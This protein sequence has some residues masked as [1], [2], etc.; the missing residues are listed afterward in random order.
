[1]SDVV[2][3]DVSGDGGVVALDDA[4]DA[5]S[6]GRPLDLCSVT[7]KF[8]VHEEVREMEF[9]VDDGNGKHAGLDWAVKDM[10]PGIRRKFRMSAAYA[11]EEVDSHTIVEVEL[12]AVSILRDSQAMSNA[13]KI[14]FAEEMRADGNRS[15]SSGTFARAARRYSSAVNAIAI[16]QNYTADEKSAVQKVGLLCFLNRAQCC[17]KLEQWAAARRD[18]EMALK[19]DSGSVKAHYRRG[20]AC[21]NLGQWEDAKTSLERVLAEEAANVGARRELQRVKLALKEATQRERKAYARAFEKPLYADQPD[22]AD[23]AASASAA[24]GG[25]G[26]DDALIDGEVGLA[27]TGVLARLPMW[28]AMPVLG[29]A[30]IAGGRAWHSFEPTTALASIWQWMGLCWLMGGLALVALRVSTG[31]AIDGEARLSAALASWSLAFALLV[32]NILHVAGWLAGLRP[33]PAVPLP[34]PYPLST[35]CVASTLAATAPFA[36]FVQQAG[37]WHAVFRRRSRGDEPRE[38]AASSGREKAD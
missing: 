2:E 34:L 9:V 12:V 20:V 10:V 31:A 15:F 14:A 18:C 13:E 33:S 4:I 37:G 25:G 28:I 16:N 17:L 3:R 24:S 6:D 26:D 5:G 27:P 7:V 23:S 29:A 32:M 1:M 21:A 30:A 38:Q 19:I 35:A 11:P 36:Y 8:W 22:R